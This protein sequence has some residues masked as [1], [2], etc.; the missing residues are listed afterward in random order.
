VSKAINI[1]LAEITPENFRA[2]IKLK[3]ADAQ[4]TFVA[5]NVYSIAESKIYPYLEPLAIYAENELVGFT[6]PGCDPDTGKYYIVRLMIDEAHQGKGYG[7]AAM[8]KIIEYFRSKP[9]CTEIYLSFV[10]GNPAESFYLNAGFELT[11]EIDEGE[12]VMRLKLSV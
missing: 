2:V 8:L 10:P 5:T 9:D 6:M 11:G 7:K 12:T 4:K 3:V 1:R